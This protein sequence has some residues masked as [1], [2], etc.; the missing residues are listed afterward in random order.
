MYVSGELIGTHG[1]LLTCQMIDNKIKCEPWFA[2]HQFAGS[3]FIPTPQE[4]SDPELTNFTRTSIPTYSIA[5]PDM[6]STATFGQK[7]S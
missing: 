5:A 7:L 6:T 4:W 2:F 1:P 3:H